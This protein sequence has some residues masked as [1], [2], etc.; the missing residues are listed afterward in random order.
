MRAPLLL[1]VALLAAPGEPELRSVP[2]LVEIG[3]ERARVVIVNEA[4]SGLARSIRTRLVG[5]SVL[6]RAH[7]AGVR[8]LAA[9]ALTEAFADEA[10]RTRRLPEGGGYLAQPDMRLLLRSALDLGW[11]LHAY[12]ATRDERPEHEDPTEAVNWREREQARNL[13]ALLERLGD[14]GK[15]LVWCG[16]S[17]LSEEGGPGP[18]GARFEPMGAQLRALT[19][20]DPFTIDQIVTVD[21]EGDGRRGRTWLERFGAE[22]ERFPLHTAGVLAGELDASDDVSEDALVFSLDNALTDG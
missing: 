13:G 16:N 4:H 14:R 9:E 19:G 17:H 21:F 20:I 10:N 2:D 15:L 22:L 12:E 6:P 1:L 8:D 7:A 18:H 5:A 11:T 3:F